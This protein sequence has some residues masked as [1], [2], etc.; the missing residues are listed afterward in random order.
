M[1]KKCGKLEI[2]L[3]KN[4]M[5][6]QRLGAFD[7]RSGSHTSFD[8]WEGM[9]TTRLPKNGPLLE[10]KHATCTLADGWHE[11][12]KTCKDQ[13]GLV[14]VWAFT[15]IIK[16]WS[17]WDEFLSSDKHTWMRRGKVINSLMVTVTW[18]WIYNGKHECSNE[19]LIQGQTVCL[20]GSTR[21]S[22]T[23]TS[24]L[25]PQR[26]LPDSVQQIVRMEAWIQD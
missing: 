4:L 23:I 16:W 24:F 22:K 19:I 3:I 17:T 9:E 12:G 20:V 25:A 13:S 26:S 8:G 14:A 18:A 2:V 6:L 1:T 21:L 5:K 7:N 15:F 10:A 11:P